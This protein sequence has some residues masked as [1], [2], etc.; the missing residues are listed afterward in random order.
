MPSETPQCGSIRKSRIPSC[1]LALDRAA[2]VGDQPVRG[3]RRRR[4]S[5]GCRRRPPRS[6]AGSRGPATR[7]SP[8]AGLPGPVA[9]APGVGDHEDHRHEG[10]HDRA[11]PPRRPCTSAAAAASRGLLAHARRLQQDEHLAGPEE[12][13]VGAR[14]APRRPAA[15][16]SGSRATQIP[17]HD[18]G[19]AAQRAAPRGRRALQEAPA[20][21]R[22]RLLD[23][24]G[25][26]ARRAAA[27]TTSPPKAR[28]R[29]QTNR[30]P[31]KASRMPATAAAHVRVAELV[32][33]DHPREDA[34]PQDDQ[35]DRQQ[36]PGARRPRSR[37]AARR[38]AGRARRR[39]RRRRRGSRAAGARAP[40]SGRVS[41][42]A[43]VLLGEL[44]AL[45]R[46]QRH[47]DVLGQRVAPAS[48]RPTGGRS[49]PPW[50]R[51]RGRR[52]RCPCPS[53][54]ARGW[55]APPPRGRAGGRPRC[56]RVASTTDSSTGRA[57]T[58]S[59]EPRSIRLT[60]IS[61][62]TTRL[63]VL[64]LERRGGVVGERAPGR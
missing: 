3:C 44:A 4:R 15:P 26:R 31:R 2:L 9:G 55:P 35:D 7:C 32:L 18:R 23:V 34:L 30:S 11:Q 50:R 46:E 20:Q 28:K 17:T 21:P 54:T 58:R 51:R 38:C 63:H 24:L 56:E 5:C 14:R 6:G 19:D 22:A 8:S 39:S 61:R 25:S 40:A 13:E 57:A 42:T 60:T 45:Q 27:P 10:D 16:G 48:A 41:A 12:D 49:A 59:V 1:E 53:R 62:L 47:V 33:A 52:R 43:S 37:C 36:Q 29:A 64:V